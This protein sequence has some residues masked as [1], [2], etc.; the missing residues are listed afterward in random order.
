MIMIH[1]P[2]WPSLTLTSR[3]VSEHLSRL[4]TDHRRVQRRVS[5]SRRPVRHQGTLQRV[6]PFVLSLFHGLDH[7]RALHALHAPRVPR[8]LLLD[9]HGW[10]LN[11][12]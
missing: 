3:W 9:R 11:A 5:S 8:V 1:L 2:F 7:L 10:I 12:R 4:H 6:C